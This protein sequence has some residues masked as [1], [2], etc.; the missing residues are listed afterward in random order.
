MARRLLGDAAGG[1]RTPAEPARPREPRRAGS[2]TRAI[3]AVGLSFLVMVSFSALPTPLYVLY[4]RQEGF[5]ASVLTWIFAVYAVG[6]AAALFLAG[7]LSDLVGRVPMLRWALL[8][9]VAATIL[10]LVWPQVP[11][12]LL[13]RVLTGLGVGIATPTA[14]AY[15]AELHA[16]CSRRP[17]P[18]KA[19]TIS[20]LVNMGGFALGPLVSGT[21]GQLASRPLV[22]PFVV[23]LVLFAAVAVGTYF[24]P[25]TVTRSDRRVRYA[26][27][28]LS[29]PGDPAQFAAACLGA[30]VAFATNGLMMAL[31]P[32]I[33][34]EAMGWTSR[35]A[36]GV[37]PAAACVSAALVPPLVTARALP[38]HQVWTTLI[39]TPAGLALL[40]YSVA[41]GEPRIFLTAGI[42]AGGAAGVLFR[43]SMATAA[44]LAPI[45]RRGE[46]MATAFLAAYC[47]LSVPVLL[48][49]FALESASLATVIVGFAVLATVAVVSAGTAILRTQSALSGRQCP[50]NVATGS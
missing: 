8:S 21:L 14:T 10:F 28:R 6:V 46:A 3:W 48:V 29:V 45:E 12:L 50:R 17:D 39:G 34:E 38:R 1:R 23:Y 42:V 43:V 15:I 47:G 36:A 20:S 33:L 31:I 25:E 4:Q 18:G 49:G 24:V 22:L 5:S 30:A 11:G 41:S 16:R 9:E 44:R 40:A 35:L 13:A 26:P 2:T 32:T 37:V 7:H 27:Q 19:A